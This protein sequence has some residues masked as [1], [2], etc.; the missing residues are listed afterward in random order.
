MADI[1]LSYSSDD[2][3]RVR[4]IVAALERRDWSVWWDREILPGGSAT[5]NTGGLIIPVPGQPLEDIVRNPR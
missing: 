4:P 3:G 5:K 2:R 1:F